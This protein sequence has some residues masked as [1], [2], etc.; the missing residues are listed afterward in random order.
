M[1]VTQSGVLN[2]LDLFE[3]QCIYVGTVIAFR[4]CAQIITAPPVVAENIIVKAKLLFFFEKRFL[5]LV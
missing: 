2:L 4:S 5:I 3:A 1:N